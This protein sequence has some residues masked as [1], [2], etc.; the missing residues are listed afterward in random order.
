MFDYFEIFLLI[1]ILSN[2]KSL[3]YVFH[4]YQNCFHDEKECVEII[5][6]NEVGLWSKDK[7]KQLNIEEIMSIGG[8]E[9]DTN[10]IFGL[11]KEVKFPI[12]CKF[13]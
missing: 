9:Q 13:I 2:F 3:N 7:S 10:Y 8:F 1:F 5:N 12:V 6:N 4:S 11:V